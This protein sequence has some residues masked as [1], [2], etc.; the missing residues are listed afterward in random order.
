MLFFGIILIFVSAIF[1]IH[2]LINK[3]ESLFHK[4]CLFSITS[5]GFALILPRVENLNINAGIMKKCIEHISLISYSMYLVHLSFSIPFVIKF[6]ERFN[7]WLLSYTA[8]Y[9]I[10]I[11]I[12]TLVYKFFE[13]PIMNIRDKFN[14]S[15]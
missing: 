3:T 13:L 6:L 11:L 2:M 12:S 5:I 14:K 8:F 15:F 4:T 9:V 7:S 1:F 10:T